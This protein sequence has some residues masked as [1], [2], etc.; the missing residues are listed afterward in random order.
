VFIKIVFLK[1]GE[2]NTVTEQF[3]AEVFIQ[4][5][6]SE[7]ALDHATTTDKVDFSS[8]WNPELLV[9]NVMGTPQSNLWREVMYAKSG[10]AFIVEKRKIKGKFAENLELEDFP[11]DYQY[12]SI[13]ISSHLSEDELEILEDDHDLSVIK[14]TCFVD[15]QQWSLLDYVESTPQISVKEFSETKNIR[16]PV[17]AVHCSAVR[18]YGF[19]IWNIVVIMSIISSLSFATFSI[20]P[21]LPQNRL[22]LGFTLTL[23]GVTFRFV[24]NQSLPKISYLT[25]IDKYILFSMIFTF[26][27]SVWHAVITLF[28]GHL[29]AQMDVGAFIAFAVLYALFQIFFILSVIIK[30]L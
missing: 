16:F 22:Q 11:F 30:I 17:L 12:L 6:W 23:T 19:F 15:E 24:T 10:E 14:A 4:A 27:V 18:K 25:R 20:T 28:D 5:R 7:K 2:I 13:L 26:L 3:E 29:Q 9:Q 1:I 21:A 8:Y